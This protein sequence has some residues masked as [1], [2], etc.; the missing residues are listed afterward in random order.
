MTKN[1]FVVNY[2]AAQAIHQHDDKTKVASSTS[3][4]KNS[5]GQKKTTTT[6]AYSE[7]EPR[8]ISYVNPICI[9]RRVTTGHWKRQT[10]TVA[11]TTTE[12]VAE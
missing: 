7:K 1:A 4:P 8:L 5:G 3:G 10:K 9:T 12:V 2:A 11:V 6:V